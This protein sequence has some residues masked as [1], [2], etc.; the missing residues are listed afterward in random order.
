MS[1]SPPPLDV[2]IKDP[3]TVAGLLARALQ[4]AM[5]DTPVGLG[6]NF[7]RQ[8]IEVDIDAGSPELHHHLKLLI[9]EH[10]R[11][12]ALSVSIDSAGVDEDGIQ[13]P[14]LNVTF[15]P[16]EPAPV[17]TSTA[18]KPSAPAA[19]PAAVTKPAPIGQRAPA[20]MP[21]S[22]P[23]SAGLPEPTPPASPHEVLGPAPFQ[24]GNIPPP[25]NP[26]ELLPRRRSTPR[27]AAMDLHVAVAEQLQE[28]AARGA[29]GLN[30]MAEEDDDVP[31]VTKRAIDVMGKVPPPPKV[32][33]PP[34]YPAQVPS[35]PQVVVDRGG[36][37]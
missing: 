18:A 33:A 24:V 17:A 16:L 2:Q 11:F 21:S 20:A 35:Q 36:M 31:R 15:T 9:S 30:Y 32:V 22:A 26:S 23:T 37:F 14:I 34:R 10:Y 3:D 12:N 6:V 25:N 1:S 27:P 13:I 29:R 7:E 4:R 8:T 19:K 28:E 5:T